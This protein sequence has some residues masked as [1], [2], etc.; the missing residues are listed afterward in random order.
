MVAVGKDRRLGQ[1]QPGMRAKSTG[2]ATAS[3]SRASGAPT[4]KWMPAPKARC[5]PG[6]ARRVEP[7]GVGEP[8]RVAVRR[9][10]QAA[11]RVAAAEPV[12]ERLGVLA[13]R[14]G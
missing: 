13:A 3:S 7:V 1:P 8:R 6:A 5:G 12:A 2:S 4:Q 14:S 9:R 10:Q 11:D